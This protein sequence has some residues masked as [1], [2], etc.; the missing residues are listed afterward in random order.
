MEPKNGG[1]KIYSR[2]DLD[3]VNKKCYDARA[4]NWDRFPYP[5]DLPTLLEKYK[6][7]K[8]G[9]KVLDIGSGTGVLAK[10]LSDQGYD[11][12]CLDPSEEMVTRTRA[13]GLHTIKSTFQD[14]SSD[15]K[16]AMVF[17]ILSWIHIPKHEWPAQIE[18][19]AQL[20]APEGLFYLGTIE[21][22][23]EGFDEVNSGYPRFF[24]RYPRNR[25]PPLF[26]KY[27]D[28]M[29]Y[30]ASPGTPSYLLYVFKR[31]SDS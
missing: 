1:P 7:N 28:L 5:N 27:F 18:K 31:K 23:Y 11:V 3:L 22:D 6:S 10:W 4:D 13:K 14:Y 19:T 20:V 26:S 21:G 2:A 12:T 24:V 25:I 16:F 9:N 29:E 8:H 30:R 15:G 17:A